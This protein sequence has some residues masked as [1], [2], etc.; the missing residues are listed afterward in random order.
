MQPP[1]KGFIVSFAVSFFWG[2][3]LSTSGKFPPGPQARFLRPRDGKVAPGLTAADHL[4]HLSTISPP[5]LPSLR[6]PFAISAFSLPS[7]PSL[8]YLPSLCHPFAISSFSTISAFPAIPFPSSCS[9]SST[10]PAIRLL[11]SQKATTSDQCYS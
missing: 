8:H 2:W 6:H 4:R 5:S 7:L 3:V 11:L 1:M 10:F 9:T